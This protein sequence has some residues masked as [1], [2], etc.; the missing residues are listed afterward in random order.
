MAALKL[1]I[2][3][4]RGSNL[5]FE[6]QFVN[7][8]VEEEWILV[9]MPSFGSQSTTGSVPWISPLSPLSLHCSSETVCTL[10]EDS[11]PR[12][13]HH[14]NWGRDHLLQLFWSTKKR[15]RNLLLCL[16][17]RYG[18]VRVAGLFLPSSSRRARGLLVRNTGPKGKS[19]PICLHARHCSLI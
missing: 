1:F 18:E 19:S 12:S 2:E 13:H 6:P 8:V 17:W 10:G 5:A 15:Y 4:A 3:R 14:G 11:Q 9:R 16:S 7:P